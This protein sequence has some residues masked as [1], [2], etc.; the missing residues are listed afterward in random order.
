MLKIGTTVRYRP[1][2]PGDVWDTEP[3]WICGRTI[4]EDHWRQPV[5]TYKVARRTDPQARYCVDTFVR[6]EQL[7]PWETSSP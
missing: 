1:F 2:W 4:T 5:I 7:R 3:W 6:E